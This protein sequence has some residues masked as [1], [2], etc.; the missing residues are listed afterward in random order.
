MSFDISQAIGS[1]SLLLAAPIALA[2]G[3][4]TVASPCCL[5]LVPG[6]LSYT[7]GM[8][9][10]DAQEGQA[11]GRVRRR[12]LA[13]TALF[14]LG[15]AAVFTAYGVLFGSISTVL[16]AHQE[17]VIRV[18][19]ALTI[20]LG[21]MFLGVLERVPLLSRTFK[22]RFTPRAG[23]AGAPLLGV[24][25]GI[26]WTPCIGPT[27]AA[28]LSLSLTTGSAARGAL[29]AFLYAL[30]V[31]IPFLLFTFALG[32]SM[33]VIAFA[34]R[35]TRTVLR[36]GGVLLV[37]VGV[38]QVTGGWSLLIQQLQGWISGYELPL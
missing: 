16:L 24:M 14:V 17:T 21:L 10:A 13:G 25:F 9:A 20:L 26:G 7:T 23:L 27:L 36:L 35:H 11:D 32:K 37:A 15:F 12:A 4:I 8:T 2:A 6:Y 30:G 1:G 3:A 33:R 29:L 34:R 5:P 38:A 31:G 22:P 18:L 19:G 28:V